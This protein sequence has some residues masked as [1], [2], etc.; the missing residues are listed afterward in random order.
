MAEVKAEETAEVEEVV[1]VVAAVVLVAG[2]VVEVVED[3]HRLQG[4]LARP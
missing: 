2:M 4:L 1:L 3:D